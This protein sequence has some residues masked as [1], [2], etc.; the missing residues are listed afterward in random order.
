V[1]MPGIAVWH[2]PFYVKAGSW[3]IYYDLRNRLIMASVYPHRFSLES[4]K[5]VVWMMMQS[6][7][8]HD[9]L[10][11]GLLCRA[12]QDYLKG[13]T[14]FDRDAE[15]LHDEISRLGKTLGPESVKST[16]GLKKPKLKCMPK[17]DLATA[18]LVARRIVSLC[19]F[20]NAGKRA[21]MLLLDNEA[22]IANVG[23][24]PYVKT[25]FIGSYRLLYRPNLGKMLSLLV[26]CLKTFTK[27]LVHRKQTAEA[28]RLN[29]DRLRGS[30]AWE[31]IFSTARTTADQ[32]SASIAKPALF[33]VGKQ[34]EL[35]KV[36]TPHDEVPAPTSPIN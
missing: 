14:L 8:L 19:W 15:T 24:F 27:Y 35:L 31:K 32:E 20:F 12:L 23:P 17:S 9:Y 22:S 6:L 4:S 18:L 34:C 33:P 7:V 25:N 28:W 26:L 29:I 5:D 10:S 1:A 13:P 30:K 11:A 2:E 3:Q 36:T 21:P 16:D